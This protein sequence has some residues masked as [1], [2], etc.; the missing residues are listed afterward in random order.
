MPQAKRIRLDCDPRSAKAFAEAIRRYAHA[1]YPPGGSE[2]SQVAFET[3]Q[4]TARD[5]VQHG[6]DQATAVIEV[7]RRQRAMLRAA[8]EWY[9]EQADAE[10]T[11]MLRRHLS[12]LRPR[13]RR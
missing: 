9:L 2:C 4:D 3:L 6:V 12:Q 8:L 5:I 11:P 7:P 13:S 1:A 10:V